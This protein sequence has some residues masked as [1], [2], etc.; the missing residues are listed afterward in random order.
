MLGIIYK[1]KDKWNVWDI[2]YIPYI[3]LILSSKHSAGVFNKL[4]SDKKIKKKKI[5]VSGEKVVI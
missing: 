3:F 4:M 5:Y 1:Q 2:Y